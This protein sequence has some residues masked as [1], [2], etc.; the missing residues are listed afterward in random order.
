MTL[1]THQTDWSEQAGSST[2]EPEQLERSRHCHCWC[3]KGSCCCRRWELE[4]PRSSVHSRD[5][6]RAQPRGQE[7]R[8]SNTRKQ[9]RLAAA[10]VAAVHRK[11]R[12]WVQRCWRRTTQAHSQKKTLQ[13]VW[14]SEAHIRWKWPEVDSSQRQPGAQSDMRSWRAPPRQ[15]QSRTRSEAAAEADRSLQKPGTMKQR[16]T[17]R[18]AA[19]AA[20]RVRPAAGIQRKQVEAA[21]HCRRIPA[22]EAGLHTMQEPV[23]AQQSTVTEQRK[24][25][26]LMQQEDNRTIAAAEAAEVAVAVVAEAHTMPV[27]DNPASAAAAVASAVAH[28]ATAD[29]AV[30]SSENVYLADHTLLHFHVAADYDDAAAA[31]SIESDQSVRDAGNDYDCDCVDRAKAVI[32]LEG[33]DRNQPHLPCAL[34]LLSH[35]AL[36]DSS[37]HLDRRDH[38]LRDLG[39]S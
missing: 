16:R 30:V 19:A 8:S 11:S 24:D 21:R 25:S 12:Q 28:N 35:A 37:H 32:D 38:P 1:R 17:P 3:C 9:R 33:A 23:A 22:E 34:V 13:A 4:Q 15:A 6:S 29:S 27:A 10:A 14:S 26:A 31:I 20:R 5:R 39:T 36:A 18:P 2:L 7:L